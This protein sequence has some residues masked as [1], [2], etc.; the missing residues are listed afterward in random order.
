MKMA[1]GNVINKDNL[2]LEFVYSKVENLET[3]MFQGFF[4]FMSKLDID[5]S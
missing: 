1:N 2:L 3:H 4:P 5:I